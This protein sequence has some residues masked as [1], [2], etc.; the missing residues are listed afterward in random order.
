MG[1]TTALHVLHLVAWAQIGVLIRIYLGLILGGACSHTAASLAWVP[2][3]TSSGTS[4]DGGAL[5]VDLPAN[6]LGCFLMGLFV[7]SDVLANCL[8]HTLTV[9]APL[10]VL[11]VKSALQAHTP[12]Q[13]GLRTGLCGSLTTFASWNLQLIIMAVG[14]SHVMLG[15][16]P[17]E[18]AAGLVL[19]VLAAMSSL[20]AGQHAA[21]AAYHRL[22]PKATIPYGSPAP[23]QLALEFTAEDAAAAYLQDQADAA[24]SRAP[25]VVQ[26]GSLK[27]L[28]TVSTVRQGSTTLVLVEPAQLTPAPLSSGGPFAAAA[29]ASPPPG[30]YSS[31]L[32][33]NVGVTTSIEQQQQQPP[34]GNRTASVVVEHDDVLAGVR[35]SRPRSVLLA[36]GAAASVALLVTGISLWRI[37]VDSRLRLPSGADPFASAATAWSLLLGPAGCLGRYYLARFN[38]TLPGHWR[39]FPAGTYAANTSACTLDFIVRAAEARVGVPAA[40]TASAALAGLVTGVGGSLSTVSTWVTEVRSQRCYLNVNYLYFSMVL[41]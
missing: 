38:G 21:L 27:S 33:S 29:A 34:A 32:G 22:N 36:D 41:C 35:R 5:F 1:S 4:R 13:V 15:A 6:V 20:V 7:S 39:W 30:W 9:E 19:G 16:Q 25:S 17:V 37:I 3:V 11:P 31:R 12:L 10:A 24:G 14:G 40:S 23:E 18:A 26:P 8:K 2:C 28:R